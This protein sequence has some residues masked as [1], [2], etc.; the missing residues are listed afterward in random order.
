M[1]LMNVKIYTYLF[2][3]L[4]FALLNLLYMCVIIKYFTFYIFD[5]SSR[6]VPFPCTWQDVSIL[7][8]NLFFIPVI[9]ISD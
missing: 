8:L 4:S 3:V 9:Q 2:F 5:T 1:S 7:F 6:A